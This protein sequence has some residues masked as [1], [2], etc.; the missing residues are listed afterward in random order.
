M[1]ASRVITLVQDSHGQLVRRRWILGD[2]DEY[3]TELTLKI[4]M[5]ALSFVLAP[6]LHDEKSGGATYCQVPGN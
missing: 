2:F 6:G 5:H 4:G 3:P 1:I